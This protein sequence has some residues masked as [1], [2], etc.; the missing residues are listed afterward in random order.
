[1]L[2]ATTILKKLGLD[3]VVARDG[4][5]A[6]A[7][8]SDQ[9][10]D[11]VLTDMQMPVM[12]GLDLARSLRAKGFARDSLETPPRFENLVGDLAGASSRRIDIHHR[13]VYGVL[14]KE[15]TVKIIRMFTLYE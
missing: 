7:L 4:Q 1:M 2:V 15:R 5:E 9:S 10:V 11:L 12:D 8:L 14:E 6:L 3:V 13:L